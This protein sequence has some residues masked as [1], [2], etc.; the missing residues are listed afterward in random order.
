MTG[1]TMFANVITVKLSEAELV[2][3]FGAN[4][5]STPGE[6]LPTRYQPDIRI[7]LPIDTLGNLVEILG[8]ALKAKMDAQTVRLETKS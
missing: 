6:A 2:L 4:F 8:T 5:P 7:A 1:A 3:E